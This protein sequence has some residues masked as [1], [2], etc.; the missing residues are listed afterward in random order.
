MSA[1]LGNGTVTFG[2][3]TVQSTAATASFP[4]P[5]YALFTAS[6]TSSWTCPVGVNRVLVLV[7][8][9]GGGSLPRRAYGG[10]PRGGI[11]GHAA[12]I[13]DVTPSSSYSY[14]VGQGGTASQAVNPPDVYANAGTGGTSSFNGVLSATGGSG[15]SA[16]SS[17]VYQGSDGGLGTNSSNST[18]VNFAYLP[19]GSGGGVNSGYS[20]AFCAPDNDT[21][22]T[23]GTNPW[24]G[25]LVYVDNT[26][27]TGYIVPGAGASAY[28][29]PELV[30]P[31][32]TVGCNGIVY[33]QYIG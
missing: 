21:P 2:D 32:G 9:G 17:T 6:G 24:T 13:F 5:G 14:T 7:V 26:G 10:N 27:S 18:N 28:G 23:S 31:V 8:G 19:W 4:S 12:C 16:A 1:K 30:S 20:A 11:G 33:I 29:N 22:V 3:S 15:V 25:V